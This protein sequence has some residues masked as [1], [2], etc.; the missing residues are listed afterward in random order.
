MEVNV[1][2]KCNKMLQESALEPR[3]LLN[4]PSSSLTSMTWQVFLKI[5]I[6]SGAWANALSMSHLDPNNIIL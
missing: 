6:E 5:S 3:L 1:N 2:C 4:F